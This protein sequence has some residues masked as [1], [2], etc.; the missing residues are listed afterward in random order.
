MPRLEA[1][2]EVFLGFVGG[3]GFG[4]GGGG[5]AGGCGCDR[6]G[7][8]GLEFAAGDFGVALG[9]GHGEGDA[10][11]FEVDAEDL[12]HD[13]LAV[14][15][16]FAGA[17]DAL[18]GEL[19]DVDE[20]F[21]AGGE[22]DEGAEVDDFLDRAADGGADGELGGDLFP[23]VFDEALEGE[24]DAFLVFVEAGDHDL[25]FVAFLDDLLG[26]A[27]AL[28]AHGGDVEEAVDAAE[29]DEGAV[30]LDAANGAFADLSDGEFVP[31]LLAFLFLFLFDDGTAGEDDVVVFAVDLGDAGGDF[32]VEEDGE[33]L[34]ELGVDLS[35]G[36]EGT[37]GADLEFEAALVD[38]GDDG[39]DGVSD[40]ECFP[41]AVLESAFAGEDDEAFAG[42]VALVDEVVF[43]AD[44]DAAAFRVAFD[45]LVK[46]FEGADA[47]GLAAD[48]DEDVG[49][50][51]SD[52]F[53]SL[54]VVGVDALILEVA[55]SAGSAAA[56][57]ALGVECWRGGALVDGAGHEVFDGDASHG[58]IDFVL[59][60]LFFRVARG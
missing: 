38:A 23:G 39:F 44:F 36:H 28:V 4:G 14:L 49:A 18:E 2:F 19:G 15:G 11:F 55:A 26:V 40:G 1:A 34:V 22:F 5:C 42:V 45:F 43:L 3:G 57:G 7:F 24:G 41:G 37:G 9:F 58:L 35:G 33:I 53:A 27:D 20:A 52:D 59:N 48:I 60:V 16:D 6:F 54:D 13:L 31:G 30:G 32:L 21:D 12:G 56:D 8:F 25:E 51:D 29:V 10:A 46:L 47:L 17:R 50:G